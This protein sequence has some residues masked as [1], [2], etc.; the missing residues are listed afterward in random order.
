MD[1][2]PHSPIRTVKK[3]KVRIIKSFSIK[4]ESNGIFFDNIF[5]T[6]DV[7]SLRKPDIIF[8]FAGCQQLEPYNKNKLLRNSP[9]YDSFSN[10]GI[11]S[12]DRKVNIPIAN[13][14]LNRFKYKLPY[15]RKPP[16]N[17]LFYT[18]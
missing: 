11:Y 1:C 10:G 15:V 9:L 4:H 12:T 6:T 13:G 14:L 7:N 3:S 5:D 16:P 2:S 17:L 18:I 8:S